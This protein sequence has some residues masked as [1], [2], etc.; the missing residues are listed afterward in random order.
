MSMLWIATLALIAGP[1]GHSGPG[2]GDPVRPGAG[3]VVRGHDPGP[4]RPPSIARR[5]GHR[6][7]STPRTSQGLDEF[8][9][10]ESDETWMVHLDVLA[11]V[12]ASWLDWSRPRSLD[13]IRTGDGLAPPDRGPFPLRC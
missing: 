12:P 11:S 9:I 10:E 7:C 5:V 13:E 2:V 4:S 1:G 6:P 3:S 8:D